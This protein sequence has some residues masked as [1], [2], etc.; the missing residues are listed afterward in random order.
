MYDSLV[1][2]LTEKQKKR[3]DIVYNMGEEVV[4]K[5]VTDFLYAKRFA[6]KIP[7]YGS[8]YTFR[9]EKDED[10]RKAMRKNSFF[11]GYCNYNKKL[12]VL[13]LDHV[14]LSAPDEIVDTILHE[15]AHAV[16][17]HWLGT[18]GHGKNWKRVSRMFG[19]TP[20]RASKIGCEELQAK[21]RKESKYKIV[22][23]DDKNLKATV[24][25]EC[26]RKLKD[27]GKR[28]MKSDPRTF[29]RLWMA[30]AED[31]ERIG[32]DFKR[33]AEVVFR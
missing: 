12:V 22:F 10:I 17:H 3:V 25:S 31:Y 20:L 30:K 26:S 4:D 19:N 32:S 8:S 7:H 13:N 1:A 2:N 29:G 21:H 6:C 9:I 11:Y 24:V 23:L 33:I 28:S 5:N 14:L 15:C 18:S 27:L 16:D